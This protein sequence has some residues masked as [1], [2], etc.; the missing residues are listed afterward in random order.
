MQELGHIGGETCWEVLLLAHG[1][2]HPSDFELLLDLLLLSIAVSFGGSTSSWPS[3]SRKLL[4]ITYNL[5]KISV[6]TGSE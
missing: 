6:K 5:F 3:S 2:G 1:F 4:Q